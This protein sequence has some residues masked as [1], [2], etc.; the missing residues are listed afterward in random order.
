MTR[1]AARKIL[2]AR[3][4]EMAELARR[5]DVSAV[6]VRDVIDGRKTSERILTAAIARAEE[7]IAEK[8]TAQAICA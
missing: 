2:R 5:F 3:R 7:I 6:S 8:A 4:G 1:A